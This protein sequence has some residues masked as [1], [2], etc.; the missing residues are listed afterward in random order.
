MDKKS[1]NKATLL[2]ILFLGLFFVCACA[3][4]SNL[5]TVQSRLDSQDQKLQQRN[6]K[7]KKE[8][9]E[10]GKKLEQR[11][12]QLEKKIKNS[13]FPVQSKL[14]DMWAQMESIQV[15]QA[16][17]TGRID[18]LERR[19]SQKNSTKG[20]D[21]PPEKWA[22]LENQVQKHKNYW[23]Q[24]RQELDIDL[25]GKKESSSK[26]KKD[27]SPKNASKKQQEKEFDFETPEKLYKQALQSFYE[28]KYEKAQKMWQQFTQEHSGHSLCPNAWFWQGEAYYQMQDYAH[29]VLNYQKVIA[30]YPKSNKIKPSMLKQGMSFFKIGKKKAGRLI[31]KELTK[32]YPNS[33]EARR[34]KGFLADKK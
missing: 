1:F 25:G 27:T 9:Q 3:S 31:L 19:L 28:R 32:K 15:Q 17:L 18:S 11:T 14:A 30:D 34:A 12:T 2:P 23:R 26:D 24:I 6:Q 33:T 22:R 21:S 16:K 20:K 29:A 5:Q 10:L 4:K 7:L 8:I 13:S